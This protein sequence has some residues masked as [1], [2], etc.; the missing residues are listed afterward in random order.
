MNEKQK[1]LTIIPARGGS[2]RIPGKNIKDFCG[3]PLIA[4][5]IGQAKSVVFSSRLVVDT[6]S[7]E[8]ASI[9]RKY[10][11]EVPRL[12][13]EELAQDKSK[14]VDSILFLLKKLKETENYTPE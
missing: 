10:G 2:K 9:A 12:R 11:A 7:E 3:K 6:D 8:I 13:P 1:V 4:Y 5:A 14:V